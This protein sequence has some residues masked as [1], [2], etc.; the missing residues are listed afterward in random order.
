MPTLIKYVVVAA[1]GNNTTQLARWNFNTKGI[2]FDTSLLLCMVA[3]IVVC[4][5]NNKW[6]LDKRLGTMMFGLYFAFLVVCIGNKLV[7]IFE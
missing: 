3:L 6:V 4:I 5:M 7:G 1:Q 2:W